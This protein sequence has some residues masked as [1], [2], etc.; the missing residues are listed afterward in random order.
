MGT[1]AV[2]I[3]KSFGAAVTGVCSTRNVEM[4]QSI[5][6]DQV[7]DYTKGD[8]TKTGRRYDI[9]LDAVGNHSLSECRRVLNPTGT[10]VMAGGTA[11]RWMLGPLTRGI[12]AGVV[13]RFATVNMVGIL[14]KP[15]RDD[16]AFLG[17][18]MASGK[19]K[20]VIDR[21]YSLNEV[22]EAIRYLEAGHAQ[23]KVVIT[24]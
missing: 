14:A 13:S 3:A 23:G 2:Q 1:F 19:I 20:P 21:R 7:V 18:L 9:I 16:L 12:R 8:F 17:E 22:P 24:I 5:G 4:V 15:N 6:A 10:L 11:G